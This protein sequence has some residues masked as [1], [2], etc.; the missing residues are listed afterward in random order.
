[1]TVALLIV[2]WNGGGLLRRCLE[3]VEQQR[4]PPDHVIVIDNAS[5]D[6][7][8]ERAATCLRHAQVIALE[9][10]TGFARANNIGAQ[11]AQGYDALALMNPDVI[12]DPEWL[13]A[14]VA[15]AD[16]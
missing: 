5:T 11:A 1:M 9:T 15:A 6:D 12:A 3:A 13:E 8:L 4:R 16:A 14:L 2:N 10:N 7:S